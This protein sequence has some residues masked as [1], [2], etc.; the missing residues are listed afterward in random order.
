MKNLQPLR[1]WLT[2]QFA[3]A[4]SMPLV[5][6]AAIVWLSLLPQ[7]R[8]EIGVRHQALARSIAGQVTT[9]LLG[10]EREL[11]AL[12]GYIRILGKQWPKFWYTL[13]DSHAHSGDVFEA[14]YIAD[15]EDKVYTVGLPQTRRD[16]REDILGLDL[17][18]RAFISEA[19]ASND[20]VWSETF[21]STVSAR[22][23]VA[24]AI[25]LAADRVVI[26][27]IT[28]DRLSVFISHL[29]AESGLFTMILDRRGRIIAD[30]RGVSGAEQFNMNYLPIVRDARSGHSVTK[31][32]EFDNK[33]FI[34]TV[35]GVKELGWSVL[36]AQ[37]HGQAFQQISFTLWVVAA[38]LVLAL[39]LAVGAGYLLARDWDPSA[40]DE[41]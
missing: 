18:R 31:D 24:W 13:L 17:S 12:A 8:T 30:S 16:S 20:G 10:A 6:V 38:G 33:A 21:L 22:L 34:G 36:V 4:A 23:A 7:M 39:S 37:P 15:R 3:L 27:E 1:R 41:Y 28:I 19:R 2:M 29:P 32:F 40:N 25:P 5:V 26:G 35:V 11:R 9:H 14:I